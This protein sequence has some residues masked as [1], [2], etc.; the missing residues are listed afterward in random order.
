MDTGHALVSAFLQ[1]GS[2]WFCSVLLVPGFIFSTD[3][4]DQEFLTFIRMLSDDAA[5]EVQPWQ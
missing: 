2:S 1:E 3:A 5:A 4:W